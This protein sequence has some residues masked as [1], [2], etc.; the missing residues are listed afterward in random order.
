MLSRTP[1]NSDRMFFT[2]QRAEEAPALAPPLAAGAEVGAEV[3]NDGVLGRG[4]NLEDERDARGE[5]LRQ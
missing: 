1:L 4:D 2:R 3:G 5:R